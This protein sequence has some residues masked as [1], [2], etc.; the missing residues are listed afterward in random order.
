MTSFCACKPPLAFFY[1]PLRFTLPNPQ[2]YD[3]LGIT[4]ERSPKLVPN[5]DG[6]DSRFELRISLQDAY[7]GASHTAVLQKR[8]TVG[9]DGV[10]RCQRCTLQPAQLQ[11]VNMGMMVMQQWVQ[12]DCRAACHWQST[13]H[14]VV[15]Q[16]LDVPVTAGVHDGHQIRYDYEGD[17]YIDRLPGSVV[18]TVAVAHHK[19]FT[20]QGNDL[21]MVCPPPPLPPLCRGPSPT[22]Y[23][24]FSSRS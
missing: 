3:V 9:L 15:D 11:R 14:R 12:P 5:Q 4:E 6:P 8:V 10:R 16:E 22:L 7:T 20:R 17:Q 19:V 2:L 13:Q 24:L 23:C 1:I 21:S 18:L